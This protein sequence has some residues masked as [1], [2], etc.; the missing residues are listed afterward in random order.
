MDL[1]R[2]QPSDVAK[3][4]DEAFKAVVAQLVT[5]QQA[6]LKENQLLYYKPVS[7]KARKFHRS[8]AKT[9]CLGGGN[10]SSKT[11]T[12]LVDA[13]ILATGIIPEDL[14]N[15][16]PLERFRGP[17]NGRIV[18]ESL[19]TTLH[20]II[21]PKLQWWKWTGVDAPGGNRGHYGWIPK[22][23]LIDGSWDRSW[24]EKTRV[25]R[26]I[27][28]NP[29]TG[30]PEGESMIQF[31]S[32]DQDPSDFASGDFHFV[33]HDEPPRY[34]IW[35]ENE[36]RTM[37]V[38]GT[39][40][41]AMTWPDDPAIPVDWLFDQVYEKAQ[42]GPNKN[43]DIEWTNMFTTENM[44]LNQDSVA[45]QAEKWSD[46][47]K[48]VRIY[49]QPIRFSNRIHPLFSDGKHHWCFKC[50]KDIVPT[51]DDQG[52]PRCHHCGGGDI[53]LYTH[54]EEFETS[55][56]WPTV[57]VLDP[58]PRKPHMFLWAQIDPK[59]DVWVVQEGSCE[60]EPTV[61]K[62]VA[63]MVEGDMSLLVVRRLIDP[64]MGRS[65]SGVKREVAWQDEFEMAGIACDLA[66][67]SDVGRGRVNEY[68]K[69]DPDTR[70]PRL[71]IHPRCTHT[72]N[73]MKRYVWDNYK[74]ALE[75]DLK[76]KPKDKYDDYPTMLKY[77]LNLDPTFNSLRQGGAV[78]RTRNRKRQ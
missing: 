70:R 9:K 78:I 60:E 55:A 69:P 75:K 31:M 50:Q 59:D 30:K 54:V 67:D 52:K 44:H 56:S 35:R 11:E 46:Q 10:G 43:P 38:N 45:T 15:D 36:A 76:Q 32:H 1:S 19:T 8:M 23:T 49:G 57:F 6:D 39:M 4:P 24:T 47:V 72:I 51:T 2:L 37:R 20:T 25:L 12:T 66:D 16:Y 77:L 21:L 74:E 17:V 3:L 7:E 34:A 29:K 28:K 22:T 71:I 27:Y 62:K 68:L 65:P 64:N 14:K 26:L 18:V 5:L 58:H 41:L 53:E 61:V 13:L 73:Q 63:D 48:K 42:D 40:Y 33:V